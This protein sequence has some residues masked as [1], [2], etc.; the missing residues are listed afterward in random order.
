MLRKVPVGIS[1][2]FRLSRRTLEL[3]DEEAAATGTS[4]NALADR[5]LGEALRGQHHP[6]I[7]FHE[8]AGGHRRAFIVGTRLSVY[9]VMA[10]VR[11]SDGDLVEAA[12][13]LGLTANQV[14]AARDYYADFRDEVDAD[15]ETAERFE[16]A[17]RDRWDRQQR[18]LA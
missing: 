7:R 11:P 15:A 17:A 13:Y 8:G 18:A 10:T 1:P 2:R 3:L 4:R 6:L 14:R 9:Q 12:D 5:L 16:A